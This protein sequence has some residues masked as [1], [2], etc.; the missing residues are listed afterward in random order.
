MAYVT[1]KNPRDDDQKTPLHMAAEGGYYELCQLIIGN[2]QEKNPRDSLQLTPLH[3]AANYGH[4]DIC[5]LIIE[6]GEETNPNIPDIHGRT[7]MD[8]AARNGYKSVCQLF[9]E[10]MSFFQIFRSNLRCNI[11]NLR[12]A[13]VGSAVLKP[14]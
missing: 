7:P 9:Q 11:Y 3:M 2:V 5:K 12:L 4:I 6:N 1:D 8:L 13:I 14:V 10:D